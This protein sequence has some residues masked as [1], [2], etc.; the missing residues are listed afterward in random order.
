MWLLK[1][2][3]EGPPA[4]DGGDGLVEFQGGAVEGADG[5]I[6]AGGA[7]EVADNGS[8]AGFHDLE[9][10]DLRRKFDQPDA[11]FYAL[12]GLQDVALDEVTDDLCKI[13]G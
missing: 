6:G 7:A 8:L 1:K 9:Q 13:S 12:L 11:A 5:R 4:E 3:R 2:L 10:G